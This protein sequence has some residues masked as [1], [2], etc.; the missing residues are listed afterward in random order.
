MPKEGKI[1]HARLL[2]GRFSHVLRIS[3]GLLC[4]TSLLL[5]WQWAAARIDDQERNVQK[6]DNDIYK[7]LNIPLLVFTSHR[8]AYLN[9]TLAK[10]LKVHPLQK[11]ATD[12]MDPLVASPIIISQDGTDENIRS[13]IEYF[14]NEFESLGVPLFHITHKKKDQRPLVG[15]PAYEALS[16]HYGWALKKTFSGD[17]YNKPVPKSFAANGTL[18]L[19]QPK[20]VIILEED[21]DIS[22]DFFSYMSATS[23][24]LDDEASNLLAVSGYNDNGKK[25]LVG[26]EMRLLRTDFFPG[27]GWMM[28]R[29]F[30]DEKGEK[31]PVRFW[32]E[33]L[34]R[35]DQRQGRQFIRPE[36][37]RTYHFGHEGGASENALSQHIQ[38]VYLNT[39]DGD[40]SK[41]DFT[42]L[43]DLPFHD[44]Y[45]S[46]ISDA[47]IVKMDPNGRDI[48]VA[49]AE[50]EK[51][52]VRLEYSDLNHFAELAKKL[53]LMDD[54]WFG[55][56]RTAYGGIVECRPKGPSGNLLYLIPAD[57]K[58]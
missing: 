33:W 54:A 7:D 18:A 57:T 51:G 27:L 28:H 21:I 44:L 52:S 47:R 10:V 42:H 13:V 2:G 56:P 36:V 4:V 17:A 22:V 6:K 1:M 5:H 9:K 53:N 30:W 32:D 12:R 23:K 19:P 31:W 46:A 25:D 45:F 35:P 38:T 37:S 26:D 24:V 15:V 34:R 43:Y 14:K 58:M 11:G 16:R 29:R 55:V 50:L 20:M 8:S 49:L 40:W 3:I 48:T 41:E 39:V